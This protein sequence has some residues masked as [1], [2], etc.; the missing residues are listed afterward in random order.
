M[1]TSPHRAR[2][3]RVAGEAY[4]IPTV[5]RGAR[6]LE[7]G[8]SAIFMLVRRVNLEKVL[9]EL[10]PFGGKILKTSLTSEQEERLRKAVEQAEAGAAGQRMAA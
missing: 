7:P 9:P 5:R 4:S 2:C 3:L 6:T 1:Q 10:E 8:S